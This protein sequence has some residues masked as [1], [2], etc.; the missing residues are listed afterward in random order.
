M[1]LQR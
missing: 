1:E